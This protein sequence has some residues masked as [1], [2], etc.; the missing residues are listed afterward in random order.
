MYKIDAHV[1]SLPLVI[2]RCPN[3]KAPTPQLPFVRTNKTKVT[4]QILNT[5]IGPTK[6]TYVLP[7]KFVSFVTVI[8]MW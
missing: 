4:C 6:T 3:S 2:T 8:T 7:L 5:Y 1:M